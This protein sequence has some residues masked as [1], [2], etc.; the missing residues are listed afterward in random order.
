MLKRYLVESKLPQEV[1]LWQYPIT[2]QIVI[3]QKVVIWQKGY[4]IFKSSN[5]DLIYKSP[6]YSVYLNRYLSNLAIKFPIFSI[7]HIRFHM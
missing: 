2:L 1:D 6:T 5:I 7:L 3:R 4:H